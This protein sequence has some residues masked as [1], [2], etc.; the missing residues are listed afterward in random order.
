LSD[1]VQ[2]D[3]D[4]HEEKSSFSKVRHLEAEKIVKGPSLGR[5]KKDR[6]EDDG[7]ELLIIRILRR[8]FVF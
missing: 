5:S 1:M 7:S 3:N 4:D 2:A 8:V 6:D